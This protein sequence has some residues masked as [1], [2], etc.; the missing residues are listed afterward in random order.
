MDLVLLFNLEGRSV[1]KQFLDWLI[2]ELFLVICY[3]ILPSPML[4]PIKTLTHF[5]MSNELL[6]NLV[7]LMCHHE[8]PGDGTKLT[9]LCIRYIIEFE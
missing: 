5:I 7:S 4:N 3:R 9:I 6:N 8:P 2:K 1:L